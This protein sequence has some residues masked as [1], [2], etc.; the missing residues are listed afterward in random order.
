MAATRV[1]V[2]GITN[3]ADAL[4]AV[5]AGADALG[6]NF[7]E[8]SRRYV[9]PED[10]AQIVGGL[11]PAFCAVGVFVNCP[12]V[13]VATLAEQVRLTAVQLHGDES[14]E[15]CRG[16]SQK[17][18]KAI[19]VRDRDAALAAASYDVDFILADAYVEGQWG[20]TGRC[21]APDLLA[22][23]EPQRL[24]LAGGLTP[25]NVVAAVRVVRPF[26]VDV[27]SGIESAPGKK[28]WS[29]MRRFID[30]VHAA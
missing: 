25:E 3:L 12:R 21:V 30:N 18:I 7:C 11:P 26:G 9:V 16:W 22:G 2:C 20:G 4:A 1:K 8:G 24:I 19:R 5:D 23:F 15:F 10:A 17:V 13:R 14:P 27:A 28:D 6:F 29:L